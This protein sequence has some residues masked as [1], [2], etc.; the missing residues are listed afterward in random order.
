[1]CIVT[2]EICCTQCDSVGMCVVTVW[3]SDIYISDV[4]SG[5]MLN[6]VW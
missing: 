6:F 2:V 1:M 5:T 4:Y 3:R